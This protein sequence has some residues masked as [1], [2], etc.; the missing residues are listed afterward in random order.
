MNG[1]GFGK[2]HLMRKPVNGLQYA[3]VVREVGQ[4]MMQKGNSEIWQ[5]DN[6]PVHKRKEVT[7]LK[8]ELGMKCM[9]WPAQSPDLSPIENMWRDIKKWMKKNAPAR[10]EAELWEGAK[11]AF[12]ELEKEVIIGYIETMVERVKAVIDSKGFA[13]RW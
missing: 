10:N 2:I 5:E 3:E 13:T 9:D 11:K 1:E 4:P 6:A 8:E 12:D 7:A